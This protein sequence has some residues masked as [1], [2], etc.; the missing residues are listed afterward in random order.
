ML[1]ESLFERFELCIRRMFVRE[2]LMFGTACGGKDVEVDG[3]VVE[4]ADAT[5]VHTNLTRYKYT[6]SG[7][8]TIL[9]HML[10]KMKQ[11]RV[12]SNQ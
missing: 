12:S 11:K 4:G 6:S 9:V 3:E 5:I 10:Y 1:I 2:V 8:V 7:I